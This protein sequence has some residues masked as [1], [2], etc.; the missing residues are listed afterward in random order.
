MELIVISGPARVGKTTLANFLAREAFDLGFIPHVIGFAEPL[1]KV[2]KERGLTKEENPKEYREFCQVHGAMKREVDP[3]YWVKKFEDLLLDIYERELSDLKENKAHWERCVI[4]D[5]CRYENE[6]SLAK[7]HKGLCV[8]LSPGAR[9]L[10][11][12]KAEWRNHH[13][14]LMASKVEWGC[15]ET[16]SLFNYIILNDGDAEDLETKAIAMAPVWCNLQASCDHQFTNLPIHLA[17]LLEE[18]LDQLD[19]EDEDE[20]P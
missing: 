10:E 17:E 7:K 15:D 4:V 8:F 3:D 20:D 14:E 11:D 1:K 6:V 5:D 12:A 9:S 2:A 19:M 18:A 16:K 13:S